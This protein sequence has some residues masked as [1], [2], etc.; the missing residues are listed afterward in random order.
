VPDVLRAVDPDG[1]PVDGRPEPSLASR[2]L[3]DL[4]RARGFDQRVTRLAR[5]G[6]IKGYYPAAGQEALAA[7]APLLQPADMVFPAY[8]EQALRLAM[9]VTVAEELAMWAGSA[10]PAWSS[11]VRRCMPA[12][13]AIGSHLPHAVG[14]ADAQRRL[15]T[16]GIAVAVFGDGATSEGD[17]HAAMNLA[18]VWN[19]PV[20]LVCQNNQYAQT[21]SLD[22]QSAQSNIAAKA[23]A[24]GVHGVQVDGMD[25]VAVYTAFA[26]AAE[27]ARRGDGATLIEL[28]MYRFGGHSALEVVAAYRDRDEEARWRTLDPIKRLE[29][30]LRD[31]GV[32]VDAVREAAQDGLDDELEEALASIAAQELTDLAA[33]EAIVEP[34]ASAAPIEASSTVADRPMTIVGA[35]AVAVGDAM[36]ADDAVVV[37]GE[38]VVTSGGIWGATAGLAERFPGRVV[39]V[40][41]NEQGLVGAAIGMALAGLRP[42]VEIQFAGFV[43]TAY[44][45]LAFH[46]ARYAWR[47]RGEFTVPLV[48]R[49]PAGAGHSGYEG[50]NESH[51][52][53]FVGTP[54]LAV[55]APATP[56]DAY[57]SLRAALRAD[58]P[59]IVL[60][61]TS[62]YLHD[63]WFIDAD[64]ID[65][66]MV[67][68]TVTHQRS[69]RI[70]RGNVATV[71]AH[72]SAVAIAHDASRTLAADGI[73]VDLIALTDV[74]PWDVEAVTDSV[75]RTGRLVVVH[76]SPG[77]A[78][79]AAEVIATI[80]GALFNEL[81]SAPRRVTQP[82]VPYG[83]VRLEPTT[84]IT[85]AQILEAVKATLGSPVSAEPPERLSE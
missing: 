70:E 63:E 52:T 53:L 8:R 44:D 2:L 43:L 57:T 9:G 20:V 50:H 83:P 66:A 14:W 25:A 32:D 60:E 7:I 65:V 23:A 48:V 46:A 6:R 12:N 77:R 45:Q 51:D 73:A 5:R 17:F 31:D 29:H 39:D 36:A 35:V 62:Q 56:L 37:L 27:R 79:F 68:S 71:V 40:P 19:A 28:V 81:K 11:R 54:G 10:A 26:A 76:D 22:A 13:T 75:R 30:L 74:V 42:V 34:R 38:D 33:I 49:M 80:T 84:A 78:G 58:G 1:R 47:T 41:L 21:T 82:N 18:G 61:P 3:R 15:G 55:N 4:Y 67:L 64:G 72:G 59:T 16:G 85:A 24:Y 69:R